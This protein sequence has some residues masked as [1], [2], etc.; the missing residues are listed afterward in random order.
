MMRLSLEMAPHLSC[1]LRNQLVA[2]REENC[3]LQLKL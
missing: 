2:V 1:K 3:Q